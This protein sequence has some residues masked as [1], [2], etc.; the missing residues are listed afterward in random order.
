MHNTETLNVFK[1]NHRVLGYNLKDIT[2]EESLLSNANGGNS[3]NWVLGHII[4]SRDDIF[5]ILGKPKL[6]SEDMIS[7][8]ERASCGYS[9]E[10]AI[11]LENLKS[12]IES[13][14]KIIEEGVADADLTGDPD[15]LRSLTF[16]AFH[17]SYHAGQT[18][19]LRRFAGKEGA[20]K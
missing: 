14:Q 6:C 13:T 4:V 18:G 9:P 19:I 11:G 3:L 20:I 15:K 2:Q 12:M 8:Y 7:L 17:E 16:L 5:E 10:K 1:F